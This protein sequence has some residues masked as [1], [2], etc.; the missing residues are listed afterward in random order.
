MI[1]TFSPTSFSLL[2]FS[3]LSQLFPITLNSVYP[4]YMVNSLGEE[5]YINQ[6]IHNVGKPH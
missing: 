4:F 5:L 6:K 1:S 3:F 2:P